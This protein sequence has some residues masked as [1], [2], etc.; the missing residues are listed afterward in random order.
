MKQFW[1]EP[2]LKKAIIKDRGLNFELRYHFFRKSK[3]IVIH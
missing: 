3:E 1:F 2:S